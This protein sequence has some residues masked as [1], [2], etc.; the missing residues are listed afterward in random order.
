MAYFR[1]T[2]FLLK[3]A[4]AAVLSPVMLIA[5]PLDVA[6]TPLASMNT[7]AL[8][9]LPA[10][11]ELSVP[12]TSM[13]V[14]PLKRVGVLMPLPTTTALP[15]PPPL[16]SP[17]T[18][19][20]PVALTLD[21]P[22]NC[23][24]MPS[25]AAAVSDVPVMLML[26]PVIAPRTLAP[27]RLG[28]PVAVFVVP[29]MVTSPAPALMVPALCSKPLLVPPLPLAVM[30]MLLPLLVMLRETLMPFPD[31]SVISPAVVVM[32]LVLTVPTV[33]LLLLTNDRAPV[34]AA[35]VVILLAALVSV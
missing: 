29:T 11:A 5:P 14:A 15:V 32:P 26:L 8:S 17:A 23:T 9:A 4:P 28:Q 24:P 12:V 27:M 35:S 16:T 20:E 18:V 21:A 1:N 33:K 34:L 30:A 7:P 3:A 19:S 6:V 25:V 10:L 22:S 13:P 31:T 2:A